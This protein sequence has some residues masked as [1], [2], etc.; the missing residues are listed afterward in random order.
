MSIGSSSLIRLKLGNAWAVF[1][2]IAAVAAA[3]NAQTF[4]TLANFDFSTTGS[5][6]NAVTQ[7]IDG[8]LHGVAS[9]G[10]FD[11]GTIFEATTS[12]SLTALYKF[13]PGLS[14]CSDGA[15]P[16]GPLVP[17]AAGILYGS[18]NWGGNYSNCSLGWG[19]IFQIASGGQ[20]KVIHSFDSSDG[21]EP[22]GIVLGAG[23][24]LYGTTASGGANNGGTIFRLSPAGRFTT[25]HSFCQQASCADGNDP[26]QGLMQGLDGALYGVAEGGRNKC[27]SGNPCGTVYR[28]SLS[29]KFTTLL[30]FPAG[31]LQGW[32][33]T[34]GSLLQTPDGNLYGS[35]DEG[36]A[37]G[38][39]GTIFKISPDGKFTT[40][41]NL[42][43]LANCADGSFGAN[44]VLATD[45]NFYGT[46][47]YGGDLSCTD[48]FR[49]GCGT[50]FK[51][52]P[53][54]VLTTLH[55]FEGP[56]GAIPEGLVQATDGNFYGVTQTGGSSSSGTLFRLSAGLDPF[57][58][59]LPASGRVGQ[60]GDII[61]QGLTGTTAVSLNGVPA[62]FTIVSD[63]SSV[64]R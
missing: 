50:V 41:Y 32:S 49:L 44:F 53:T 62:T 48:T 47:Q 30:N 25:L 58:K 14:G 39:G 61:G 37:T 3:A 1:L 20:L 23:R 40:I 45:G 11:K 26:Q 43:S 28:I 36:G 4:T 52:T 22:S 54:G 8:N 10:Q 12:G 24:N 56:D 29:G 13:C 15:T 51:I 5:G 19:V 21:T 34:P 7:G 63:T 55:T 57:V 17:D 18:T 35:T 46:T 31:G 38:G 27:V 42:C 33:P 2:V 16:S 59:L 9:S 64:R 6:A 60:T